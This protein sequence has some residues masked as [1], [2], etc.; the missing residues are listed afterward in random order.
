MSVKAVKNYYNQI[1]EQYH[2]MVENLRDLEVECQQGLV[3]P[4]R[5]DRL[6]EQIAPL[7]Q[8]YE[9]WAFMMYL[10]NQPQKKEKQPGYAKRNK[11]FISTLEKK[12]T[13]NATIHENEDVLKSF[14][15]V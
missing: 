4:E 12:N 14:K 1:C 6:K 15:G 10:L 3:D 7:K 9:R 11:K 5:I 8:N 2:E 13:V